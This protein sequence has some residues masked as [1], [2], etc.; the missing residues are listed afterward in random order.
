VRHR[1][2]H[3]PEYL[4][5]AGAL[6]CF[7]L[8]ACVFGT[9]FGH[10]GSP[11]VIAVGSPLALRAMMGVTMA[12]TLIAIV[13][14]PWGRRS[15]AQMNPA[16]TLTFHRL[17]RSARRDA[18]GY[19][20]AQFIGGAIGVLTAASL[21]GDALAAPGVEYVVTRPG[22]SGISIAF[23]AE[24]LISAILMTMVLHVSSSDRWKPYTGLF[25]GALV[26]VYIMIEAPLSGMSMNPARTVASAFAAGD[27]MAVWIYFLAPLTG[28][29]LAAEVFV[30]TRGRSTV[31]CGKYMHAEPCLFC[32][33]VRSRS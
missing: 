11:V 4:I 33:H 15:G 6:G 5:E 19:V 3:L 28:M 24:L 29:M 12:L 13:Y 23:I 17:G 16:F 21:L 26:A 32:A 18:T 22:V 8:S 9:L 14:S 20:V 25:A 27:W 30:R 31:P 2:P 7:M 10:P 1:L